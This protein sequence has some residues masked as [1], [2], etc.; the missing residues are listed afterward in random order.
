MFSSMMFCA[1]RESQGDFLLLHP[2]LFRELQNLQTCN[3]CAFIS[4][5]WDMYDLWGIGPDQIGVIGIWEE[6]HLPSVKSCICSL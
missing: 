5:K 4:W 1:G 2:L 3:T 6:K